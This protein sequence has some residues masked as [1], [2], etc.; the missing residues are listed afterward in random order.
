MPDFRIPAGEPSAPYDLATNADPRTITRLRVPWMKWG[1][2][3]LWEGKD[4]KYKVPSDDKNK[5]PEKWIDVGPYDAAAGGVLVKLY[6]RMS[7]TT[8]IR[9]GEGSP[10]SGSWVDQSAPLTVEVQ[11]NPARVFR[12]TLKGPS[13]V[14]QS[15]DTP[16]TYQMDHTVNI[17]K[18][19]GLDE[20]AKKVQDAAKSEAKNGKKLNHLVINS[21]GYPAEIDIWGKKN[22]KVLGNADVVPFFI[23]L[24]DLVDVIWILSCG[25][26]GDA[27]VRSGIPS[28][29]C[30]AIVKQANCWLV[31]ATMLI[32]TVKFKTPL[33]KG[34]IE[35]VWAC[36][37]VCFPP[38]QPGQTGDVNPINFVDFPPQKRTFD[39]DHVATSE[40]KSK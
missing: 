34:Q 4:A 39:L 8:T 16:V 40:I 25:V 26:A 22:S 38:P 33:S 27:D 14:L 28:G 36:G 12:L 1:K 37:P 2:T 32:P 17:P 15:W 5:V 11:D 20:I 29:F 6:G 19:M 13:M 3:F 31:A 9:A 30:N 7:G 23:K 10:G 18:D 24:K 21:H 35:L